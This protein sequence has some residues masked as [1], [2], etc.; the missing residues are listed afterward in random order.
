MVS[1]LSRVMGPT[2]QGRPDNHPG[3]ADERSANTSD[4]QVLQVE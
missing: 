4:R 1:L 3:A 2:A